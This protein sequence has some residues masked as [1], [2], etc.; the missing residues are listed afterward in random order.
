MNK[1][2]LISNLNQL[3]VRLDEDV[4]IHYIQENKSMGSERLNSWFRSAQQTL[5]LISPGLYDQLKRKPTPPLV[6]YESNPE[7]Y[8][9]D[10]EKRN[11]LMGFIDSLILD[12]QNDELYLLEPKSEKMNFQSQCQL[13]K[14]AFI[15][16]G[17]DNAKKIETARVLEKI[18]FEA[19]ILHEQANGGKTIIEKLEKYTD[20]GFG[21]VLYTPDDVGEAKANQTHLKPRARQN[22][23]FEHGL[24]IGKLG[25]N[26]VFPVVTDHS[27]ELPG[28]ISGMVYMSDHGWEIQLAK[29]IKALG[30]EVD[31][32]K[33]F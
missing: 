27:L 15:V 21:I 4:R 30:Y 10:V 5:S 12:V 24:L 17:H 13:L 9:F 8:Y 6:R 11:P 23:V 3:K 20:V 16:H 25:R 33:L 2:Q 22:V 14:K 7:V 31:F 29:E 19:I 26:K 1:Q 28:D 18:G 32:N